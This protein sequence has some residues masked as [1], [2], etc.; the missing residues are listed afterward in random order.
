MSPLTAPNQL[1]DPHNF[2]RRVSKILVDS[3]LWV[4]K[5]RVVYWEYLFLAHDSA[6]R[7]HLRNLRA[8]LGSEFDPDLAL[9][10]IEIV[11]AP[12]FSNGHS[13]FLQSCDRPLSDVDAIQLGG[14]IG[15]ALVFGITDLH[16]NNILVLNDRL[17]IIDIECLFWDSMIPSESMLLFSREADP[18]K[19]L[20]PRFPTANDG[21]FQ[22]H[23]ALQILTG[24]TH[25]MEFFLSTSESLTSFFDGIQAESENQQI[26][27]LLQKTRTYCDLISNPE[28]HTE[29]D[30][31]EEEIQQLA[32]A[33]I[34]YFFGFH[35]RKSIHF[36]SSPTETRSVAQITGSAKAKLERAFMAPRHLLSPERLLKVYKHGVLEIVDR[37]FAAEIL[38]YENNEIRIE[39]QSRFIRAKTRRFTVQSKPG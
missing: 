12:D 16:C 15:I 5:P 32:R 3:Y 24:F 1:G 38:T 26:R 36:F 25:A 13:R 35:G 27:I 23:F 2:G 14:L 39:K 28:D 21:Q 33:D 20:L 34:P 10:S 9:G 8:H 31:L 22:F 6:L 30:L 19:T 11:S 18:T 29:L 37:L 4:H 7:E 17:Q